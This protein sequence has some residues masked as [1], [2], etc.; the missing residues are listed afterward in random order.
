M[1]PTV[2]AHRC[3]RSGWLA[4]KLER[5]LYAA[6]REDEWTTPLSFEVHLISF[7]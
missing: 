3:G 7:T 1:E 5:R 6:R 4:V 2:V